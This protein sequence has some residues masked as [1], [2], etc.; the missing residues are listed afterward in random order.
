MR[1]QRLL[2]A[3][4][5]TALLATGLGGCGSG[6]SGISDAKIASALGL[7]SEGGAYVMDDNPAFCSIQALLHTDQEVHDAAKKNV[8][9]ASKDGTV[10]IQVVTPF[11]PT[12]RKQAEHKLDKLARKG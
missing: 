4:L 10:G 2:P 7:K 11:A 12:C 6:T 3:L 8:V 5:A 1:P 9:V